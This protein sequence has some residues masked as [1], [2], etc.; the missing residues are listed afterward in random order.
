MY[1]PLGTVIYDRTGDCNEASKALGAMGA[2]AKCG[3]GPKAS[4]FLLTFPFT[5]VEA[6]KLK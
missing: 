2:W 1:G 3:S 5:F 6:H 4:P